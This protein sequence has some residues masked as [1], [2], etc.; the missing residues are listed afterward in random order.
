ME[1]LN[2]NN[3]HKNTKFKSFQI[4][5][6]LSNIKILKIKTTTVKFNK[7]KFKTICHIV[8]KQVF[9]LRTTLYL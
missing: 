6:K 1:N 5:L 3:V 2:F 7:L 4:S 8:I 9:N